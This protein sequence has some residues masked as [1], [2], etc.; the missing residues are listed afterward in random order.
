MFRD[1]VGSMKGNRVKLQVKAGTTPCLWRSRKVPYAL[2][3]KVDADRQRLVQIN[4]IVP[5]PHSQWATPVMLD[6]KKMRLECDFKP[7]T[8]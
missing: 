3:H 1:G 7:C 6:D 8:I 4:I 5:V 2:K